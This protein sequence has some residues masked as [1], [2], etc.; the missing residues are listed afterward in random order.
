[1]AG[2]T[3]GAF[4]HR[5][6]LGYGAIY[7]VLAA[8]WVLT[9]DALLGLLFDDAPDASRAGTLKGLGFVA[10][11]AVLLLFALTRYARFY[12]RSELDR[13]LLATRLD[14]LAKYANDSI[15]LI[16][17]D[18]R[19]IDVNDCFLATY[20]YTREEALSLTLTDWH[21][22]YLD[23]GGPSLL[24]RLL[25][26]GSRVFETESRAKDGAAIPVEI[27]STVIELGGESVIQ[28]IVR[29]IGERRAA[30]A[31]IL[32]LS[33]LYAA[34][35]AANQ[36]ITRAASI[37]EVYVAVCRACVDYGGLC[38]AWVGL[39]DAEGEYIVPQ[40]SFGESTNYLDHLT[41][42]LDDATPQG[43]GPEAVAYRE[44]RGYVCNDFTEDPATALWHQLAAFHGF[45]AAIAL[46]LRRGDACV[47]TLTAYSEHR[48]CFD[49]DAVA[50]LQDL[51]DSISFAMDHFD[52]SEQRLLAEAALRL[53]EAR[54]LEAQSIGDIGDWSYDLEWH[55]MSWSPQM[56]RLFERD[57]DSGPPSREEVF[58]YLDA[59]SERAMSECLRR[60]ARAGEVGKLE[61]LVRLPS[62]S[63]RHHAAVIVP[64]TDAGG[65]VVA[66]QGTVQDIT[67]RKEVEMKLRQKEAQ[68]EEAQ[69]LAGV[70][71]WEWLAEVGKTQWSTTLFDILGL[72]ANGPIPES[73]QL[74]GM[75]TPEGRDIVREAAEQT[76]RT[77][78]PYEVDLEVACVDGVRKWL[79]CRGEARRSHGQVIGIYGTVQDVTARRHREAERAARDLHMHEL[80]RRLI[81]AQ[82]DERRRLAAELH[83][84]TSPNLAA[85]QVTLSSLRLG[86]PEAVLAAL[87]DEFDDL[88]ALLQD[89]TTSIRDVCADLRPALLDYAGL[90]SALES[91]IQQFTRRTGVL[92][93]LEHRGVDARLP[94]ELEALLFRIA[95]EALANCAKHAQARI[96]HISLKKRRQHHVL[97]IADDGVG[98]EPGKVGG[99]ATKPGLGL[100][101]MRERAEFVGGHLRIESAPGCG[102]TLRVEI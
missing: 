22:A 63:Q 57:P 30:E 97:I 48:D 59:A 85:V 9:S 66:L 70:G 19:F 56:Y 94:A 23:I 45:R 38:M 12:H 52:R 98:F 73:D 24:Q 44:E 82:E 27:S 31:R 35:S 55:A 10:V 101:T 33:R 11:T 34:I 40:A 92:V 88:K 15:A 5:A 2:N 60:A 32:A 6:A 21:P 77:G 4:P 84:R 79:T 46:P 3:T 80:S 102:T 37:E 87:A 75:L 51:A 49:E 28:A 39:A 26:R 83:D 50:L 91:H 58:L 54:L 74:L 64:V 76:L 90:I 29:D 14:Y 96:I 62:G 99:G 53:S 89:T 25:A 86:M 81:A 67:G 7:A 71:N 95:Q 41:V 36:A 68:L 100:L 42:R 93:K 47:G 72:P 78:K 18:G 17:P 65:R 43:R 20:G 13:A 8:L 1:M 16:A 69:R 61:C